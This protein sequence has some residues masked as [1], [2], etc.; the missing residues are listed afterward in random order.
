MTDHG[1]IGFLASSAITKEELHT[2]AAEISNENAVR[3]VHIVETKSG[4]VNLNI[5]VEYDPRLAKKLDELK[6]VIAEKVTARRHKP[7]N[8]HVWKIYCSLRGPR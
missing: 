8:M 4:D 1:F 6:R 3:W 7:R 5:I 2:I